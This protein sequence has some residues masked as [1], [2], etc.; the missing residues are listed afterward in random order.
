MEQVAFFPLNF[1]FTSLFNRLVFHGFESPTSSFTRDHFY[2][3]YIKF[4][5][6]SI[7]AAHMVKVVLFHF[8]FSSL[9][10]SVYQISCS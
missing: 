5:N 2:R 6:L 10:Q 4:Q 9:F 1:H 8:F 3:P 7:I